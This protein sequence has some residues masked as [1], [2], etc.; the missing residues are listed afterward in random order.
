MQ[1]HTEQRTGG[2]HGKVWRVFVKIF[3]RGQ[4]LR[5]FLN[6]VKNQQSIVGVN[7]HTRLDGQAEQ[8]AVDVKIAAKQ[9]LHLRIVVKIDVG[10]LFKFRRPKGFHHPSF[11]HLARALNNH[12]FAVWFAFPLGK[13]LENMALYGVLLCGFAWDYSGGNTFFPMKK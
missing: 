5:Y 8:Q 2:N 6:F 4:R 12:R 1:R 7:A 13:G 9:G 11:A 10:D 3:Q